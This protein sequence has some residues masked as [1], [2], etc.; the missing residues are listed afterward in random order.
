MPDAFD[1]LLPDIQGLVPADL[2]Q[3]CFCITLDR[4]DLGTALGIASGDVGLSARMAGTHPHLFS[5][6][7][8]FLPSA[9]L[10][11]MLDTVTAI[12]EV[13][14]VPAF[15]DA[16]LAWAPLIAHPGP[17]PAGALMGYDFHL[18]EDG[19]K[20]IEVNTNAGGAFLNALL[21]RAQSVCCAELVHRPED[22]L[23]LG[24]EAHVLAMFRAEWQRQRGDAPLRRIAIVDDAPQGQYLYPEFVLAQQ[25]LI[26]AGIDAVICDPGALEARDTGLFFGN[27]LIDLVYNRLVDFALAEPGHAALRRAYQDGVV[28]LTPNP[29]NHALLAHKRNLTLLSDPVALASLGVEPALIAR[30]ATIPQTR[31]VTPQNADE[32]WAARRKLFFK[33]VSGHGGKAVY[34]GDKLTKSVWADI[35]AADYVAQTIAAPGQR[36]IRL[37]GVPTSRKVDVRLYTYAAQP[38]LVA[39]RIYQ[40]QTTNFRTP[41]GGF[42]P[43]LIV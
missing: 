37:D 17:G 22:G 12:E 30:L 38:L 31:M 1:V 33:P 9:S 15:R 14:Q 16:A 43:V 25:M 10:N 19:P 41:G 42:A 23:T 20:L 4:G 32:L 39:A 34:R 29:H 36:M 13:A 2:N 27:L 21:A 7:P 35:L 18:G 40:G 8:V 24:F 3:S 11:A 5:N 28:V 6:V 26:G